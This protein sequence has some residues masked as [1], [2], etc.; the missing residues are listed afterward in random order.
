[1]VQTGAGIYCSPAVEKDKVFVGDDMGRLTAY[2][3]KK[4]QKSYGALN[5]ANVLSVLRP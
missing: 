2:A 4:R 1:M 5:P 3:L